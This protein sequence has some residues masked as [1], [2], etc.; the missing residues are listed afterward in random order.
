MKPTH[1]TAIYTILILSLASCSLEKRLYSNGYHISWMH[2]VQRGVLQDASQE[3]S[4]NLPKDLSS[5]LSQ[6]LERDV[7]LEP[8]K[9]LCKSQDAETLSDTIT[10][11]TKDD[12]YFGQKNYTTD[13][14]NK[15]VPKSKN[16]KPQNITELKQQLKDN[17]LISLFSLLVGALSVLLLSLITADTLD[18][19]KS[20]IFLII[21]I[22]VCGVLFLISFPVMLFQFFKLIILKIAG[23]PDDYKINQS[24]AAN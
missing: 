10:P 5:N 13:E 14:S 2:S 8:S 12:D 1:W 24:K 7:S 21:L 15:V 4:Q 3:L 18:S 17:S 22:V 16:T 6:N 11:N 19:I 9:K 23:K 20:G